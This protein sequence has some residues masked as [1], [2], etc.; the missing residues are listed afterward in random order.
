[1]LVVPK[2]TITIHPAQQ[3]ESVIYNFRFYPQQ[4][5]QYLGAIR[6]ISIPYYTGS[7][8]YHYEMTMG[9]TNLKY[10]QSPSRGLVN[11]YN[12]LPRAITL[13]PN[14]RFV[15]NDKLVFLIKDTLILPS[16]SEESPSE[17]KVTLHA[18][19]DDENGEIIGMR[20]NIEKGT[21]LLIRNLKESYYLKEIW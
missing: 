2:A 20:G 7:V 5:E 21:P 3:N 9:T 10:I 12:K 4:E 18:T 16:G 19:E 13:V 15:T 6:Q 8:K 14:T 1:M 11:I 17:T